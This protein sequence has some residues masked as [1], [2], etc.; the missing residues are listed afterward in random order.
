MDV[1]VSLGGASGKEPTCQSRRQK[2]PRFQPW[3]RKSPWRR[4][5]QPTPVFLPR[6]SRGQRSLTGYI[7][8]RISKIPTQL[9]RLRTCQFFPVAQVIK[10]LPAMQE[11]QVQSLVPEDPRRREW[12]LTPVY[13]PG[14][15]C[16]QGL[17]PWDRQESDMAEWLTLSLSFNR[18]LG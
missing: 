17:H 10:N 11:T 2:R 18:C 4:A 8:H 14:E 16:G 7:V 12:Q 13:L 3:I 15:F 1:G 5:W 9:K 6:E